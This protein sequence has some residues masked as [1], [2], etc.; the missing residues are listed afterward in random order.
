MEKCSKKSITSNNETCN[1]ENKVNGPFRLKV[2]NEIDIKKSQLLSLD[3]WE[4]YQK[5]LIRLCFE[6]WE[7]NETQKRVNSS[8]ANTMEIQ[9]PLSLFANENVG[10]E[11]KTTTDNVLVSGENKETINEVNDDIFK[12]KRDNDYP[13]VVRRFFKALNNDGNCNTTRVNE[14]CSKM[15]DADVNKQNRKKKLKTFSFYKHT[16]KRDK[17]KNNNIQPSFAFNKSS[18]LIGEDLWKCK[19]WLDSVEKIKNRPP[20]HST[21]ADINDDNIE[22][23]SS[24]VNYDEKINNN[25]FMYSLDVIEARRMEQKV[26]KLIKSLKEKDRLLYASGSGINGQTPCKFGPSNKFLDFFK[27][28]FSGNQNEL[29][30]RV[31][32]D[33]ATYINEKLYRWRGLL[34][35]LDDI[36]RRDERRKIETADHPEDAIRYRFSEKMERFGSSTT[37]RVHPRDKNAKISVGCNGEPADNHQQQHQKKAEKTF[38]NALDKAAGRDGGRKPAATRRRSLSETDVAA[39]TAR[40][41]GRGSWSTASTTPPAT[42]DCYYYCGQDDGRGMLREERHERF[43]TTV[44]RL[45][46]VGSTFGEQ[47]RLAGLKILCKVDVLAEFGYSAE[48][49]D[50]FVSDVLPLSNNPERMIRKAEAAYDWKFFCHLSMWRHSY[51]D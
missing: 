39:A 41:C 32:D 31:L 35:C 23:N 30:A 33:Y 37:T 11:T 18:S 21:T 22:A 19:K 16:S 27:N 38:F 20:G 2:D 1:V 40:I 49:V 50:L 3:G 4:N 9:T 36:R 51:K 48:A 6:F 10:F 26:K 14:H 15:F 24:R 8:D 17:A 28:A 29:D 46:Y 43:Q 13:T 44:A 42:A 7:V 45:E 25:K 47:C 12:S 5:E 34:D